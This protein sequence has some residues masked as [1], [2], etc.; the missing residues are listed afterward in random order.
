MKSA[1]LSTSREPIILF[2]LKILAGTIVK[3][4]IASI[5]LSSPLFAYFSSFKREK[6]LLNAIEFKPKPN[7][8]E[9]YSKT[10]DKDNFLL[11][12]LSLI[13]GQYA[14]ATLFALNSSKSETGK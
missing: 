5:A 7:L 4:F 10:V 12:K 6:S 11:C 3:Y 13:L 9:K 14:S 8:F 2:N 1:S